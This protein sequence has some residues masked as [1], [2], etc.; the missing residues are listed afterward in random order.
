MRSIVVIV[1]S[2]LE[3]GAVDAGFRPVRQGRN[4]RMPHQGP[5]ILVAKQARQ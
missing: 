3:F 1:F 4:V 5:K 2:P